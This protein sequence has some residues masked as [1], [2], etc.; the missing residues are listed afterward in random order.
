MRGRRIVVIAVVGGVIVG[1]GLAYALFFRSSDGGP[2]S[3]ERSACSALQDFWYDV[4]IQAGHERA[5]TALHRAEQAANRGDN[6][7]LATQ[8]TATRVALD[9]Y[10][11]NGVLTPDRFRPVVSA[12]LVASAV[13]NNLGVHIRT[14]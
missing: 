14:A 8:I 3:A 11:N 1:A 12:A 4:A 2:S 7:S 13:C 10:V 6:H 9:T 5:E